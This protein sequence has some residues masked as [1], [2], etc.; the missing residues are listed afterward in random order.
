[1]QLIGRRRE[2]VVAMASALQHPL[3]FLQ[4]DGRADFIKTMIYL[5]PSKLVFG[6]KNA[7]NISKIYRLLTGKAR[8]R[9][10]RKHA[11]SVVY[12]VHFPLSTP[13]IISQN[14]A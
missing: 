3:Q 13:L 6:G 8:D 14:L 2:N 5:M 10:R 12:V 11:E 7:E 1:M 4:G 9:R